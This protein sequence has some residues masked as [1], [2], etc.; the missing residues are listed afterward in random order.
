MRGPL[1]RISQ[2]C[3]STI[4]APATL[5]FLLTIAPSASL[6]GNYKVYTTYLWHLQQP[7]YWPEKLNGA[8]RYMFAYEQLG[9]S[10]TYPGHP[11]NNLADIFGKDDRV[12]V[13]QYRTRDAV[14]AMNQPDAGAQISYSGVLIE[15]IQSL[16]NHNSL[17]YSPD[18]NSAIREAMGWTTTRGKRKIEPV[19]FPYHH[20]LVPLIDK[21]ALVKEISI[22]KEIWWKA[23]NGNPDKSDHPK[24]F[25]CPEE[26]FTE[27]IIKQLVQ[28]GYEWVIVAN[29]HLA[30]TLS[31][32][33][34][35]HGKGLYD[36]PN[37]ADQ[38]NGT[39]D[40]W[41]SGEIDGR[42]ATLAVPF[43]YQA[44]RAKYVDPESGQEYKIIIV[45]MGDIL[46]YRDGYSQQGTETIDSNIAPYASYDHPCITLFC[47]DGDNAWGGGYSY[48]MEA[49]PNFV[50]SAA[51]KG[52]RPT[53][54]QTFLDENPPP[55]N[56]VVHV[57]DGAWVNAADDWGHPQF[58]NWLWY[59]QRDRNS[60]EYDY[61]DPS[62]YADIEHGWAEDF[63]NWA[64]IVAAQNYV[65]TA[66]QVYKLNGGSV[67]DW[68][69][70]EPVQPDGTDNGANDVELAWHFFLPALTSGY[71]YYGTSLDM[72]VKPTL[73]C[74]RAVSYATNVLAAYPADHDQTGPTVFVPQ[75]Y[76]YN[77]GSTNYGAQ[78]GY[79][80]WVAPSDFY[81]WTLAYD[82]SGI[83]SVVLKVRVDNDGVN[84]LDNND[85]ETYAG[86]PSVGSWTSYQ[87]N[88]RSGD[89]FVSNIFNNSEIDFFIMPTAIADEYWYHLTGY[90]NQLL[91]YYIEARDAYG[92]L[93]KTDIQHV[94]VGSQG[95][96]TPVVFS[97]AEPEDCDDLV[98]R[99]DATDRILSNTS[100][101]FL[102]ITFDNW[103]TSNNYQMASAGGAVW[104]FTN[105][106]P[107]GATNA[108]VNFRNNDGSLV[109]DNSGDNW[110]VTIRPCSSNASSS[111]D[112]SPAQPN[113][114][115][116]VTITYHPGDGPLASATGV[117]IH[118]G[119]NGWQDIISPDPAMTSTTG[120]SWSYTYSIPDATRQINC[121]FNDGNGT[122]DNNGGNDWAVSVENC[123]GGTNQTIR[124]AEGSP[125]I[126]SDPTNGQNH[127]GDSFD[128]VLSGGD[129]VTTDQG[130]FGS[131]GHLYFNYDSSNLYVGATDCS[132]SG[133]DNNAMIIFL[134]FNTLSDNAGNLWDKSGPPNGLDYLHNLAF[135]PPM[136]IAI[137]LGDEYGDGTFPHFDL[138]NGY[139]FGQ[140]VFYL[141]ATSFVPVDG[142]HLSQFDGS[143]TNA[144]TSTDDDGDRLTERWEA[145]I[146]WSSLNATG[147]GSITS[148]RVAGIFANDS[149]SGNDRYLS[150]NYLGRAATNDADRDAYGNF[151]FT[152]VT[153]TGLE[154]GFPDADSDG[155]GLPDD[156][157]TRYFGG[158]TNAVWNMDNDGDGF[159]NREEYLL[160]THPLSGFSTFVVT[161]L[162]AAVEYPRITWSTVGGKNYA[163]EFCDD[164]SGQPFQTAVEITEDDVADGVNSSETYLDDY[165]DTGG[166]PTNGLR[167][168]R[169]RLVT[170]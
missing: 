3:P 99:Y 111:V 66:E 101:V 14:A 133:G 34:P 122:W 114:C 159:N 77:P 57:E 65:S 156:W 118:V 152:F 145:S 93:K 17:G 94:Y 112:F 100:P 55:Q 69:I 104:T 6:A 30:R 68:K 125:Q 50:S 128:F 18:W 78:Y 88:R 163:V 97:P 166:P 120:G 136:D 131:F 148:C 107:S 162:N 165:S 157:E 76:P 140:G 98:T 61:N 59:P 58:L 170:Q 32:Y 90:N 21:D 167:C 141:S 91:D 47:H 42:G 117:Y 64:V 87:M 95:G 143:G 106:V 116:D 43:C 27:R 113:G 7:N 35:L 85:N 142:A 151:A 39:G 115:D 83:T 46:S 130:G 161:N 126:S 105:S 24:G 48:Y 84:P 9:G 70:Q 150:G 33:V 8:N 137:V 63:R 169:V 132:L 45:P 20:A 164:L 144:T 103:S 22:N 75:R 123:S 13:Y 60:P 102:T 134:D 15:N 37:R 40:H 146:P 36:P 51:S 124:F 31:N 139:D 92:N 19:G 160:G 149:V 1:R 89:T 168:Y 155:D 54:I 26:A 119:R 67:A 108:V 82:V 12:A 73:A 158:P 138:G 135:D 127:A 23:W 72:E 29:H 153:L 49:V 121:A 147:I 74:N 109:D 28:A 38:V 86:G 79:R 129:A 62:T 11:A 80:S 44:H 25:R 5:V 81:I 52:Y 41:W 10:P 4:L 16:G 2:G 56:D 154:V 53:T 71:M 96:G 110:S